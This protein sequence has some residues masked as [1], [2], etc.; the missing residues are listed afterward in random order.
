MQS[1]IGVHDLVKRY[2]D[3][4]AVKGVSFSV[5]AGEC[6]G[7]LGPNGAGKTS[8]MRMLT[9]VSPITGGRAVVA[10]LDVAQQP[11]EVKKILGIVPQDENLD[12]DLSVL[13]N[14]LAHAR[15]F[16]IPRAE[17]RQRAQE[18]LKFLA[19]WERADSRVDALSGGMKRRLVIARALL[20]HPTVLVL[21]EPTT[22]LDPAGRHLVW[23][24]VLELRRQGATIL[25]STH[26][27]EEA[28]A[29][30]DRLVIIDGGRVLAQGK[31][32]DLVLEYAGR[33]VVEVRPQFGEMESVKGL[34]TSRGLRV[35]EAGT[36]LL[37]LSRN[38]D[39]LE[40]DLAVEG[41]HVVHRTANLEDVF[42]RLT[43]R[44]LEE[45]ET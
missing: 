22:G 40:R 39:A 15:Y 45:G 43:G 31:P 25:L 4:A 44:G 9:A 8:T 17:A 42:L 3:F 23:S 5:E 24:R 18:A 36:A 35:E 13:G 21:D 11:R 30:C 33:E 2:G 41:L 12:P 16:R 7:L 32:Q 37:V 28:M 10:G 29:L 27:M 1:I 26:N 20:S 34:L 38:G 14:L 19:L 6:F